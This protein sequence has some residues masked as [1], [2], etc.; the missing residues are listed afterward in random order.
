LR[1]FLAV[2]I[3][4]GVRAKI[5]EI[6]RELASL[7]RRARWV[8]PEGLHLTIRFFGEVSPEGAETLGAKLAEA[9]AGLPAFELELRGCGVFPERGRPRV[10]FV[11][12]AQAPKALFDLQSRAE[13]CARSLGF[14]GEARRY[15]PH[16]TLAR[17]RERERSAG[18]ILEALENRSFGV[19]VAF[20]A[21]LFESRLSSA[22]ARY[23]RLRVFPLEPPPVDLRQRGKGLV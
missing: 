9:L 12:V 21:V 6:P 19:S 7:A 11:G 15:E 4:A 1:V 8:R 3:D 20:E 18:S 22:G 2:E 13:A 14:E 23:E 16:L 5:A 10:L 17:F